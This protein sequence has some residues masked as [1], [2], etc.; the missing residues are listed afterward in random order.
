MGCASSDQKHHKDSREHDHYNSS[1]SNVKRDHRKQNN[2]DEDIVIAQYDFQPASDSD[3]QFKKGD[4]LKIINET[5]EWWLAKSL[6]TGYEG[7]IPSA[8]VA[9]VHTLEMERWFFKDLSR[10]ETERLLLAPGNKPGSF[11]VRES[12]TTKGQMTNFLF[13]LFAHDH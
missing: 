1:N 6:V 10:R 9:R 8:Y 2:Q 11:L 7:F 13:P 4:R 12:E 5:G 3:L